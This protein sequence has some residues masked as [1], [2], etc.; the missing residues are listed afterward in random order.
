M[1]EPIASGRAAVND[2]LSL[3]GGSVRQLGHPGYSIAS[4]GPSRD[5][6]GQRSR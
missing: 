3:L 6:F 1:T 5:G 2:R 4:C